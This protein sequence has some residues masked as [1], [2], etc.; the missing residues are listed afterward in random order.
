MGR[1]AAKTA[2][3]G[4]PTVPRQFRLGDDTLADLDLIAEHHGAEMGLPLNRSDAVRR[5]A[6]LEADRIRRLKGA[7]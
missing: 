4:G 6:K 5:A 7:K 1:K 3:E 2:G